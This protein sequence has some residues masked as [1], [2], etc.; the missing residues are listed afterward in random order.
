MDVTTGKHIRWPMVRLGD[1]CE[2]R[3]KKDIVK[4]QL[5]LSDEVTFLPMEDLSTEEKYVQP[6]KIR[7]LETVLQG[8]Y[9]FFANGD[10]LLAKV[11]PCFENGKIGIANNLVNGFGFGSSEYIVLRPTKMI[12]TIPTPI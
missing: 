7:T 4:K 12:F 2:I 9:T 8:S 6:K 10:V 5:K 11:T 3:P 1:V